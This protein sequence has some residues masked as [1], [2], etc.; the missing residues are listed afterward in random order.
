MTFPIIFLILVVL[1]ASLKVIEILS[2]TTLKLSKLVEKYKTFFSLPEN[3]IKVA[4]KDIEK[5]F[6]NLR[7]EFK[8]RNEIIMDGLYIEYP[9]WWFSLRSSN[10]EPVVRLRVE[11]K[12]KKALD[13]Q[14]S[15]ILNIINA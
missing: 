5:I 13:L 12:D 10:T 8:D 7:Q 1:F 15:K 6:Y 4:G 2:N 11:A 14:N 9:T 3:S